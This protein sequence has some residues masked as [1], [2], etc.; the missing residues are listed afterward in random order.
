M[1][2]A[3]ERSDSREGEK[4]KQTLMILLESSTQLIQK[5]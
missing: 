4:E 2:L 5:L 1:K 3:Q